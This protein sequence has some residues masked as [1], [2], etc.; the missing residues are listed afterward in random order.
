MGLYGLN[1]NKLML[2]IVFVET[3]DKNAL[4]SFLLLLKSVYPKKLE[5]FD[6]IM[7]LMDYINSQLPM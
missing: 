5:E 1:N 6:K 7:T 2:L 3:K 4:R